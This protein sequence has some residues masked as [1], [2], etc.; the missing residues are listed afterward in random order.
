M[1][2]YVYMYTCSQCV[3]CVHRHAHETRGQYGTSSLITLHL[4]SW[5]RVCHWAWSSQVCLAW[6]N[7]EL[8]GSACLWLCNS[9]VVDTY[10][11]AWLLHHPRGWTLRSLCHSASTSLSHFPGP[12]FDRPFEIVTNVVYKVYNWEL[13]SWVTKKKKK[14]NKH[15]IL[16]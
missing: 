7:S 4:I 10:H 1:Y 16:F 15:P 12:V 14:E 8:Q 6:L 9:E 2:V 13:H 5:D 11:H 3:H